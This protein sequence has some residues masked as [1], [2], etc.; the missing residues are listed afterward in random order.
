[1][2][3]RSQGIALISVLWLLVLLTTIAVALT[4]TIP[5]R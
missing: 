1:M 3:N 5:C 4:T 2:R